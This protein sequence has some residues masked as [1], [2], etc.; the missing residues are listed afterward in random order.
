M[1][2]PAFLDFDLPPAAEVSPLDVEPI[3]PLEADRIEVQTFDPIK[4]ARQLA[5]ELPRYWQGTLRVAGSSEQMPADLELDRL[6]PLEAMVDV[7][8]QLTIAGQTVPVQGN[9]NAATEQLNLLLLGDD[10]PADLEPGGNFL[11]LQMFN[12]SMWVGPRLTSRAALLR[13]APVAQY[14]EPPVRGLW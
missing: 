10:L 2:E 9:L 14:Q 11:G 6:V 4:R 3:E 13:L 5:D 12:I 1:T 8:G 7:F